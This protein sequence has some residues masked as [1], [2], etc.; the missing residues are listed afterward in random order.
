[1]LRVIGEAG[2]EVGEVPVW[3]CVGTEDF[4]YGTNESTAC[5][6]VAGETVAHLT[7]VS[8]HD[9]YYGVSC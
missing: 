6:A 7:D 1:M 8:I 3:V 5:S 2:L 4:K 9:R